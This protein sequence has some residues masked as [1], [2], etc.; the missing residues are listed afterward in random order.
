MKSVLITGG[1]SG[2]GLEFVNIFLKNNFK[3]Y[4]VSRSKN[5]PKDKKYTSV[6]YFQSDLTLPAAAIDIKKWLDSKSA[7]INVLVNNAGFG[8]YGSFS[9]SDLGKQ[10][11]MIALNISAL[12]ELT[13]ALLPDIIKNKGKILNVA[14]TAAFAPGPLMNVYFATKHYV[15]AFSE[16]LSIELKGRGIGVTALCPGPTQS[17]FSSEADAS[18]TSYFS[19]KLPSANEVAQYGYDSLMSG[20]VVA[21]HGFKN[22][23][24]TTLVRLFPRSIV[25]NYLA[26]SKSL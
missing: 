21:V 19:G 6:T 20:K 18:N 3:V 1:T 11:D 8:D 4:V 23:L 15:L 22:R 16:G 12:T 26:K 17:N 2:I 13:H 7:S 9:S 24:G 14:S 10:K 5:M 25:R